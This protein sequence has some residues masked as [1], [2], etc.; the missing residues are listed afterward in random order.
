MDLLKAVLA[1]PIEYANDAVL[2]LIAEKLT[3]AKTLAG[4]GLGEA[5]SLNQTGIQFHIFGREHIEEGAI[6]QMYQAAKL[7]MACSRSINA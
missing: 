4:E 5:I 1:S 3:P 6:N 7:P 2:G